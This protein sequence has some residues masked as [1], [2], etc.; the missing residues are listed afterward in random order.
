MTMPDNDNEEW[1][2]CTRAPD[3]YE[4][5]SFGRVRRAINAPSKPTGPHTSGQ[6]RRLYPNS[7]NKYLY[8]H[9][10]GSLGRRGA[11]FLVHILV[12]EAFLAPKPTPA[13]TVNHIDGTRTNNRADNLEWATRIEQIQHAIGLG[14]MQGRPSLA[15]QGE[16]N[17]RAKLTDEIVR[18]IL[19]A[20]PR[21][22]QADLAELFGVD[23]TLISHI[24]ARKTWKH[25][26]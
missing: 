19:Y 8:V 18:V 26:G 11:T 22:S 24:R 14:R 5:S 16:R 4:V 2:P 1:R 3:F 6:I 13:H 9:L 23:Q 21:F 12:A 7:R 15:E 10:R 20:P 17:P 25:V